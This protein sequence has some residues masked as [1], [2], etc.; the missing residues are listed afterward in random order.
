MMRRHL[1]PTAIALALILALARP[2][3]STEI[4][5]NHIDDDSDGLADNGCN[6][7]AVTG[8]DE[9]PLRSAAGTIAPKTGQLIYPE[10]PDLTPNVAYGPPLMFQRTYMSQY[11]P[12]YNDPGATDFRAP[13]GYGW[14][15]TYMSWLD[16]DTTPNPDQVI[17]HL[18]TGQ[19]VLFTYSQT[20]GGYDEY[21]PQPGY[22]FAYLRQSTS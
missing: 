6:P 17:V 19:D 1:L 13:L 9:S 15:H 20:S 2:A 8:V 4:C 14:Q 5:G 11:D 7:A 3:G 22:H 21:T 12:G 10:P 18:T 16:K